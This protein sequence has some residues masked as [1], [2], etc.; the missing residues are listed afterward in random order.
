MAV[1]VTE[2]FRWGFIRGG[3]GVRMI[4]RVASEQAQGKVRIA[5]DVIVETLS[6]AGVGA[7]LGAAV[8]MAQPYFWMDAAIPIGGGI[9]AFLGLILG[10]SRGKRS[11][12]LTSQQPS[13]RAA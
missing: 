4:G 9:G 11:L 10:I 3:E 1:Q 6:G 13:E 12:Q 7:M 5:G 8:Y 2:V